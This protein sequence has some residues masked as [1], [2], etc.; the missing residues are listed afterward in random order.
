[1]KQ[2]T[3]D[4]G[5]SSP[6][7][8][9]DAYITTPASSNCQIVFGLFQNDGSDYST[10]VFN[11]PLGAEYTDTQPCKPGNNVHYVP[12]LQ[13]LQLGGLDGN[14]TRLVV[15]VIDRGVTRVIADSP[16]QTA[17]GIA[18]HA[19]PATGNDT[20]ST[21]GPGDGKAASR[22]VFCH[23]PLPID[24]GLGATVDVTETAHLNSDGTVAS[25]SNPSVAIG[26]VNFLASIRDS[27]SSALIANG[28]H[29]LLLHTH[30]TVQY[31]VGIGKVQVNAPVGVD[32][33]A[34]YTF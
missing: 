29:S 30:A 11:A 4:D 1:M 27:Q 24:T 21:T 9:P 34:Y 12:N 6:E 19:S 16:V 23:A 31:G 10:D 28:G 25:V 2:V 13:G 17:D 22:D 14:D 32:C 5:R 3:F 20:V 26:S 7:L 33:N 18:N 8:F 15:E